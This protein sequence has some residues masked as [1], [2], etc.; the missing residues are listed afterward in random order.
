MQPFP[1]NVLVHRIEEVRQMANRKRDDHQ[2][3]R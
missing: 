1:N 2:K 3:H